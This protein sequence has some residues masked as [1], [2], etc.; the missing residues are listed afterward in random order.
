MN[1]G[2]LDAAE[3]KFRKTITNPQTP[4]R[5][6]VLSHVRLARILDWKGQQSEAIKEYRIVLSLEDI[7]GSHDQATQYLKQHQ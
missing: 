5:E 1:M 7:E 6:K 4:Q 2:K 3:E